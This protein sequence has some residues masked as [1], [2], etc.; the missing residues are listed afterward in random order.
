M[1]C[2]AVLGLAALATSTCIL[3]LWPVVS[4]NPAFSSEQQTSKYLERCA[5]GLFLLQIWGGNIGRE[6]WPIDQTVLLEEVIQKYT[7]HISPEKAGVSVED[8][9]EI[10]G[11]WPINGEPEGY[12]RRDAWGRDIR[13]RLETI[14]LAK[15]RV[16]I[17][18]LG[19]N[20]IDEGGHGD[21]LSYS[22]QCYWYTANGKQEEE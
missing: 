9:E 8:I 16:V 13:Y 2:I 11:H 5:R 21:D 10:P 18:S 15:P 19:P 6:N 4:V 7:N 3:M 17:W 14:N 20:G 1:R 12:A 22:M